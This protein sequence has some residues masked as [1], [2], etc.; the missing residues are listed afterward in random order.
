[1]AGNVSKNISLYPSPSILV[2]PYTV[3]RLGDFNWVMVTIGVIY[4]IYWVP[5]QALCIVSEIHTN[6]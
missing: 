4:F 5:I 2:G 6:S 3:E 1:M